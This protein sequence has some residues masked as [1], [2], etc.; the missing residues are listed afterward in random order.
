METMTSVRWEAVI[1]E[2]FREIT[3][4]MLPVEIQSIREGFSGNFSPN[5]FAVLS[6]RGESRGTLGLALPWQ[7]AHA[8]T[9]LFQGV[10]I[11]LDPEEI[12]DVTGELCNLIAGGVKQRVRENH[13]FSLEISVPT[14]TT[15]VE[16]VQF[17]GKSNGRHACLFLTNVGKIGVWVDCEDSGKG[18]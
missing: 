15:D 13:G 7:V 1:E 16:T 10:E 18:R 9:K 2:S 3:E 11:P 5:V 4:T 17:A 14:V 6:F 8:L 12:K